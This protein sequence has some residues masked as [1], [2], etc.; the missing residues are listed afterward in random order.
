MAIESAK[1]KRQKRL[2]ATEEPK[3]NNKPPEELI[4]SLCKEI[5]K[6]AVIIP[7]CGESFCSECICTHLCDNEF[8]CPACKK[9]KVSPENLA[10][11]KALRQVLSSFP[12]QLPI[13]AVFVILLFCQPAHVPLT[14]VLTPNILIFF[15][16]INISDDLPNQLVI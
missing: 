2:Q 13:F 16:V 10:P 15:V 3:K 11:N 9:D 14:V 4:C 12:L 5:M 8:T 7:C 6:E 1:L